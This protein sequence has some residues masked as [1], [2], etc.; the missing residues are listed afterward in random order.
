MIEFYGVRDVYSEGGQIHRN[1]VAAIEV[2]CWDIVG[3]ALKQPIYNLL[4][5]RCHERVRAYANGWYRG[6]R[7]PESFAAKAKEKK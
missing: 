3:K 7:D 1:A 6:P 4:G 5:G 2:A